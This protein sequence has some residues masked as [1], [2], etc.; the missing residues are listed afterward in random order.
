MSPYLEKR[1]DGGFRRPQPISRRGTSALPGR[2][3]PPTRCPSSITAPAELPAALPW[4]CRGA[5][6]RRKC[7]SRGEHRSIPPGRPQLSG[8]KRPCPSAVPHPPRRRPRSS[9]DRSAAPVISSERSFYITGGTLRHDAPSYVERQADADL[10]EGL[11]R[12]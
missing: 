2:Y 8:S 11:S 6:R 3:G 1:R 5:D 4:V 12:G 7:G 9:V 10:Y